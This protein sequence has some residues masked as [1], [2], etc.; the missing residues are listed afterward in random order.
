MGA[1]RLTKPGFKAGGRP[2][3]VALRVEVRPGA[4]TF[5]A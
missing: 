5:L 2:L 1:G 4:D 3:I